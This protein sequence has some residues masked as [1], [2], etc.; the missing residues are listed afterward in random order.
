M[1]SSLGLKSPIII[2]ESHE[3]HL[4]FSGKQFYEQKQQFFIK[5]KKVFTKNVQTLKN[6]HS[7]STTG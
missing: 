3:Q 6:Y 5:P 7:V 2:F 1:K 4:F